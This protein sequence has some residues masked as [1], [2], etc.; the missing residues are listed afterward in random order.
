MNWETRF[1]LQSSGR[2]L[3]PEKQLS[4]GRNSKRIVPLRG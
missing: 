1:D 4:F 3:A 2:G